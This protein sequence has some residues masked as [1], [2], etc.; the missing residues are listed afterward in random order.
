M[1]KIYMDPQ[2]KYEMIGLDDV[3]LEAPI[4]VKKNGKFIGVV[5]LDDK[6]WIIRIGNE[7]GATGYYAKRNTCLE[8]GLEH[9]YE[10]FVED[11]SMVEG[12]LCLK[13]I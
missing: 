1:K 10:Y 4:F 12:N 9:G 7:Y 6:G 3:S 2:E 13:L 5:L 11:G 8:S